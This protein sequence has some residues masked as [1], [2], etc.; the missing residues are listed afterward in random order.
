MDFSF[1]EEQQA[2]REMARSFLQEHSGSEQVR[3]AMTS[4]TG[5]D[6]S[7]WKR[8]GSELGWCAVDVPEAYGGLGLGSVELIALL[9]LCG[10]ALLCA[11]F[12]S[13]VA[14][15]GT[16]LRVAGSEA[17]KQAHL[18]AL[19]EG[20]CR[21]ALA[22]PEPGEAP[23]VTFR[24][25]GAGFALAGECRH[26]IDGVGADLLVTAAREEGANDDAIGLFLVPGETEGVA[27]EA[28]P[29]MDTT[30]RRAV[31]RFDGVRLGEDAS[32][33]V[34]GEAAPSL[35]R[36]Q[37]LGAIAVAAECVGIGQRC[38]D[39]AVAY[40]KERVQF[41]HTIGSFQSIKH[42]CA[43]VMVAVESARSAL[44][45][46]ACVAAEEGAALPKAASLAKAK[47][48]EAAFRAAGESLQI[49]G[50]VGFTWEYDVHLYLKRARANES[51]LGSPDWHRERVAALLIDGGA[52]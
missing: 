44:Y 22:A 51:L 18:P 14:L 13:T 37:D 7:V 49:H 48:S 10:E 35:A 47:A 24:R 2:L 27:R 11:P 12:L 15:G 26:V 8:I 3:A 41:G 9:E 25:E 19:A 4:P 16:A 34:A 45:Y 6:E 50:G 21:I 33:G 39:L 23:T 40:A 1:T 38:L 29:T 32:L 36:I 5:F 46:A 20:A 30:R 42:K 28:L 52:S 43:D 31:L 17:Q